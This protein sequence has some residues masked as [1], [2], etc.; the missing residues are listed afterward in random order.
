VANFVLPVNAGRFN[1]L[2]MYCGVYAPW[3]HYPKFLRQSEVRNPMRS[4][5][6]FF[7]ANDV[8]GHF[9]KL[10]KWRHYVVND[11]H[12]DD[13]RFGPGYLLCYYELNI[14]LLECLY[15]LL[16]DYNENSY[17]YQKV[18]GEQLNSEKE[19]W[20]W[21]PRDLT[22]KELLNP[23]LVIKSVFDEIQPE[24][25][26]DHLWEWINAALS[27]NAI[28]ETTTPGEIITVYEHIKKMYSA[29]WLIVQRDN[30]KPFLK[31]KTVAE[32]KVLPEPEDKNALV[33]ITD[34]IR[35]NVSIKATPAQKLGL[36]EVTKLILKIEPTV[37]MVC[38]F[39][40]SE[41]PFIF[42]LLIIVSD[43]QAFTND[44]IAAKIEQGCAQLVT[45]V[46]FVKKQKWFEK[47]NRR[48]SS[49]YYYA[50]RLKDVTYQS[51]SV[52]IPEYPKFGP[53][54]TQQEIDEIWDRTGH[55]GHELYFKAQQ[56]QFEKNYTEC[57]STVQ[58]A[59][60]HSLKSMIEMMTGFMPATND[61]NRLLK[62]SLLCSVK[63][64]RI[65][66]KDSA[67]SIS[68]LELLNLNEPLLNDPIA[69]TAHE[70]GMN[71][72]MLNAYLLNMIAR[73]EYQEQMADVNH[74]ST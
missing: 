60:G 35:K 71:V 40:T 54:M 41:E 14:R 63:I 61:H 1:D 42:F 51:A 57:L 64:W 65:F 3:D 70:A 21:Y 73:D 45:I 46:A 32:N 30:E 19:E 25:F 12:Y 11:E 7:D 31:E 66:H 9:T 69:K 36:K 47:S 33:V 58:E 48:S 16:L 44:E 20:V 56:L 67:S 74:H 28:D 29:A 13:E 26:R 52:T 39:H 24:Q 49:F 34:P 72:L 37:Q 68:A 43:D 38:H 53:Y 18:D 10:K 17:N 22:E 15:I 2:V 6:G 59:I 62:M 27:S 50:F 23:Y 55:H 8:E 5:K 4:L